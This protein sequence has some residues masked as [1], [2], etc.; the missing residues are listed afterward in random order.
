M[1]FNLIRKNSVETCE[2]HMIKKVI[3]HV[4]KQSFH[5]VN[6]SQV[7]KEILEAGL[8]YARVT[9]RE[10][11]R[12]FVEYPPEVHQ[13]LTDFRNIMPVELPDELSFIETSNMP[14][15]LC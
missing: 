1:F 2:R 9:I 13:I 10:S 3:D 11:P 4:H 5:L 14:L 12:A 8:V 15:N 7:F 6:R